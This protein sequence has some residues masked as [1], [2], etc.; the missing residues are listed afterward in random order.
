MAVAA[1]AARKLVDRLDDLG[2][3]AIA[4]DIL[5]IDPDRTTPS[6]VIENIQEIAPDDPLVA[7]FK[8]MPDY[9]QLFADAI[10]RKPW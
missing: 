4:F 10:K 6:R 2:A 1:D 8:A 9:D 7:R 3:A 5:F